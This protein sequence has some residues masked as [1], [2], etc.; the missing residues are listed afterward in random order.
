MRSMSRCIVIDKITY[1]AHEKSVHDKFNYQEF[2][3]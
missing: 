3:V 2:R 1:H